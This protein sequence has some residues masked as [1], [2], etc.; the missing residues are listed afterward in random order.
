MLSLSPRDGN[1]VQLWQSGAY[2]ANNHVFI[3]IR[4][5]SPAVHSSSDDQENCCTA[6]WAIIPLMISVLAGLH[7]IIKWTIDLGGGLRSWVPDCQRNIQSN[8][9]LLNVD[10]WLFFQTLCFLSGF[11]L[12]GA[13]TQV[14]SWVAGKRNLL[15]QRSELMRGGRQINRTD[16]L[17]S[18]HMSAMITMQPYQQWLCMRFECPQMPRKYVG[19]KPKTWVKRPEL[20]QNVAT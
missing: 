7:I 6:W 2:W 19:C 12:R 4:S 1:E 16:I 15:L 5:E 18:W 3:H 13:W 14:I 10:V 9:I 17:T 8:I 20:L 11:C